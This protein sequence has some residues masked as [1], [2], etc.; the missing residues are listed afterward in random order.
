M[1]QQERV[2]EYQ[3]RL[4]G[5][6]D[7]DAFR[8]AFAKSSLP[9]DND[10]QARR[11]WW[12][13]GNPN[14]G[15]FA[16][17]TFGD[18]VVATCYIGGKPLAGLET[19]PSFEIGETA[20]DPNHQRKGLFSKLVKAVVAH[21]GKAGADYVYGTPNSQS[22]PGY[23]KLGFDIVETSASWLFLVPSLSYWTKIS[24]PRFATGG[25][26]LSFEEY[27]QATGAF[28]RLNQSSS[29]YLQWRLESSPWGYRY[30]E[31]RRGQSVFHCAAR[32]GNLGAHKVIV[33]AEHFEN[34][35]RASAARLSGLLKR[36]IW[37]AYSSRDFLG[38]YFHAA[39]PDGMG[40]HVLKLRGTI[41]HRVLPMCAVPTSG[42]QTTMD[43]FADFQLSDCDIG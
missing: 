5:S 34:G 26:E 6:G 37:N 1:K 18:D 2:L 3:V 17:A 16:V 36:T 31:L 23:A 4:F 20:T 12:C 15:A 24:L 19:A 43:W 28:K 27:A 22:T 39:L 10:A 13:F 32:P 33:C 11:E 30:F 41:P 21:A 7:I 25:R 42:A 35:K 40:R 29:S 9:V 8:Q 38:I 14:G